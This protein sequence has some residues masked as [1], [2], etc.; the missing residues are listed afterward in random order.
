MRQWRE[1]HGG[2]LVTSVKATAW[3]FFGLLASYAAEFLLLFL[4]RGAASGR[5]WLPLFTHSPLV[6]AW[7]WRRI[8][9]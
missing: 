3:M 6:L 1:A 4:R 9:R 8:H 5:A 7:G 2:L